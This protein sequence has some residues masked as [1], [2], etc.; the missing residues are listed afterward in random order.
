MLRS[1]AGR[2]SRFSWRRRTGAP[3]MATTRPLTRGRS[4]ISSTGG[5]KRASSSTVFDGR[6]GQPR[7]TAG[8]R[9]TISTPPSS[10]STRRST[11]SH[12]RPG[13]QRAAWRRTRRRTPSSLRRRRRRCS[14]TWRRTWMPWHAPQWTCCCG[15]GGLRRPSCT[16]WTRARQSCT[17]RSTSTCAR[18]QTTCTSKVPLRHTCPRC[19]PRRA[20]RAATKW[21]TSSPSTRQTSW[22]SSWAS[23]TSRAAARSW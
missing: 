20:W 12:R 21:S 18:L 5:C 15:R 10:Q 4:K 7:A 23:S 2:P 6:A 13:C 14:W 22:K 17:S 8:S 9:G 19:A 3:Q 16:C 1:R 11:A